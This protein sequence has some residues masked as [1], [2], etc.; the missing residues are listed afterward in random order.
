MLNILF[1]AL[2]TLAM[3]IGIGALISYLTTKHLGAPRFIWAIL[4]TLGAL[5]GLY[6]MIKY[7]LSAMRAMEKLDKER[8]EREKE[9]AEQEEKRKRWVKENDT[10]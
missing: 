6:S 9:R 7:I 5:M 4:L 2:Y 8:D 3:P 10:E 1:Q